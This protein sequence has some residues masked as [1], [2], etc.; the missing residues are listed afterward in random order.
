MLL[1]WNG[2]STK[3]DI[4]RKRSTD[5]SSFMKNSSI[6]TLN[7]NR[8][9]NPMGMRK[10][11]RLTYVGLPLWRKRKTP[12]KNISKDLDENSDLELPEEE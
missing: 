11:S 6:G 8:A 10:A 5:F 3:M 1:V 9:Q 7:I 4:W 2:K 12:P